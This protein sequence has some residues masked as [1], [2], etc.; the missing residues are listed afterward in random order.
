MKI[1]RPF[2]VCEGGEHALAA[3]CVKVHRHLVIPA[4]V[5]DGRHGTH[6]EFHMADP[7]ADAVIEGLFLDFCPEIPG[8]IG[9]RRHRLFFEGR[10]LPDFATL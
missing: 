7:V 2:S 1:N 3:R 6:A 9:L 5:V 8:L 4:A 10:P